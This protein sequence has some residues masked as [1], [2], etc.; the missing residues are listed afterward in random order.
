MSA[1][2]KTIAFAV[3]F[4]ASSLAPAPAAFAQSSGGFFGKCTQQ[5][6]IGA[7]AGALLGALASEHHR[8]RTAIIGAAAGGLGTFGVCRWLTTREQNRVQQSYYNSLNTNHRTTDRW[9]GDDGTARSLTVSRPTG[10]QG[11]G[12]NCRTVNGTIRD[13]QQGSQAIPAQT[14]CRNAQ[15]EW[16]PT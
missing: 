2:F 13:A 5:A 6:L 1:K 14:F 11:Y 3:A 10:A 4:A 12:S 16:I 8:G 15:G 9:T 7:G